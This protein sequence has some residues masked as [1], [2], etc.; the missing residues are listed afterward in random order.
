MGTAAHS[1]QVGF[2][3]MYDD[4]T[5]NKFKFYMSN[6]TAAGFELGGVSS[7]DTVSINQ[8]THV[9]IMNYNQTMHMYING[10]LKS[11]NTWSNAPQNMTQ[12]IWISNRPGSTSSPS[13]T[14]YGWMDDI[15][16]SK[17]ALYV[18]NNTGAQSFILPNQLHPPCQSGVWID[19]DTWIDT[20]TWND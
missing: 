16:I 5:S 19:S 2:V 20:E 14:F 4:N 18:V 13:E 6:Y 15:R 7:V 17:Q 3:M 1:A 11:T 8:W 12:N 9:S 10:V